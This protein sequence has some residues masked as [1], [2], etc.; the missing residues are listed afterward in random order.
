M[1]GSAEPPGARDGFAADIN[2]TTRSCEDELG[3]KEEDE[4][5]RQQNEDEEEEEHPQQRRAAG[6]VCGPLCV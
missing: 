6:D 3:K 4:G 5:R 1:R 2:N